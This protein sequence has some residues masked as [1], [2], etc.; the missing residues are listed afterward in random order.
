MMS[1]SLGSKGPTFDH[2]QEYGDDQPDDPQIDDASLAPRNR[3]R[4]INHSLRVRKLMSG[5][6][7][8]RPLD[9][10]VD[11]GLADAVLICKLRLGNTAG[12]V[13]TCDFVSLCV[14]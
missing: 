14:A 8:N 5:F 11:R 13:A 12:C 1:P 2:Q 10:V 7:V 4:P 3:R 9:A 6:R